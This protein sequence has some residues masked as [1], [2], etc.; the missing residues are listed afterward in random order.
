[1][2]ALRRCGIE[3]TLVPRIV[4]LSIWMLALSIPADAVEFDQSPYD[5]VVAEVQDGPPELSRVFAERALSILAEDCRREIAEAAFGS[6]STDPATRVKLARWR[7]GAQAYLDAVMKARDAVMTASEVTVLPGR[8]REVR[9]VADQTQIMIGALRLTNQASLESRIAEQMCGFLACGRRPPTIE[10]ISAAQAETVS[11]AW[12]FGD[13]LASTMVA[14]DGLSCRY[15]DRLH[16][17]LKGRVC[18]A[19]LNEIRLMDAALSRLEAMGQSVQAHALGLTGEPSRPRLVFNAAGASAA[20]PLRVLVHLPSVLPDAFSWLAARRTGTPG[21][22][23]LHLP[24]E[25]I[26]VTG[27]TL[28]P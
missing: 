18:R 16:L 2:V 1:M 15:E 11:H 17:R 5:W 28:E 6:A 13:G 23:S 3:M 21:S 9:I 27:P 4:W 8:S 25:V 26:Y 22:V 7:G 20:V 10:E 24:N 14:S 19:V 12:S